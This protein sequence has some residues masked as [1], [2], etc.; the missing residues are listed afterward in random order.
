MVMA[1]ALA[2]EPQLETARQPRRAN[3]RT[4]RRK[5]AVADSSTAQTRYFIGKADGKAPS[6]ERE[7][8]TEKEA[9]VESLRSGQSYFAIT[10]WRAVAD[11]SKDVPIIR[12]EIVSPARSGPKDS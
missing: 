3:R 10:E 7:L 6:L 11:I 5:P 9:M 2:T 4:G 1:T 8:G 12:K